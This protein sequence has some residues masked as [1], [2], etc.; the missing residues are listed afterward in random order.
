M[1]IAYTDDPVGDLGLDEES[2]I[3]EGFSDAKGAFNDTLVRCLLTTSRAEEDSRKTSIFYTYIKHGDKTYKV[4]M[5]EGSCVN[6][7]IK[8]VVEQMN[9]KLSLINSHTTLL[10]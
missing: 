6:I 5:D 3:P 1:P 10:G 7:I 4:M 8:S 2:Y 9:K